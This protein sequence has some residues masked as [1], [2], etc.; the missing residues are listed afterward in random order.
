LEPV[1][2]EYVPNGEPAG[3]EGDWMVR[4]LPGERLFLDFKPDRV[5][6]GDDTAYLL[7]LR[8]Y[9]VGP[10]ALSGI[11]D[12]RRTSIQLAG[13]NPCAGP[14]LSGQLV[15]ASPARMDLAIYD[16]RGR[17]VR[18][19]KQGHLEAGTHPFQWDLTSESHQP[20]A[21]GL[22]FLRLDTPQITITRKLVIKR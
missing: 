9:Y 3:I 7:S 12:A 20:V 8:G 19:I 11:A 17:L 18:R 10:G 2:V 6:S 16:V 15:M 13:G 14:N 4:L 21:A 5:D 22:Y 1:R